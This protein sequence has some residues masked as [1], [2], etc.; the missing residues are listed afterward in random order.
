MCAMIV[1]SFEAVNV[2][3]LCC[4]VLGDAWEKD[5]VITGA[6]NK[7]SSLENLPEFPSR[8]DGRLNNN[9][10]NNG[11]HNGNNTHAGA[12][13][14]GM[15]NLEESEYGIYMDVP[16]RKSCRTFL[17]PTLSILIIRDVK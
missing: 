14:G 10:N 1:V 15:N 6:S 5:T 17:T 8:G 2:G 12:G 13:L 4:F 3:Y 11:Y 16:S 9:N 7:S